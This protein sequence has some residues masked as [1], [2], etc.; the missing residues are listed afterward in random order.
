V[1]VELYFPDQ[2]S[3]I[4]PYKLVIINHGYNRNKP[5]ANKQ[6]SYLAQHLASLGYYV[7][8]IQ[9][10]LPTDDTLIL[11]G[12]A[13]EVRMPNWERGVENI[14]FVIKELKRKYRDLSYKH[15]I[16]LGHSSGGD[17]VMLYAHKYPSHVSKVISL[18]NR[19]MPI[20]RVSHPKIYS[21]R[22]SD[23]PADEGVLPTEEEQKKYGITIIKQNDIIH[24][25]M[26]DDAT[27]SQHKELIGWVMGFLNEK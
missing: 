7:A 26:D 17:M 20:P 8:S 14:Q 25:D 4:G 2:K 27:E 10:E 21:I 11:T 15:I 13:R 6:Y 1:P 23:Q 5:G 3:I 9:H 16:L 22:S 24:N 18:D 19:R 12:N